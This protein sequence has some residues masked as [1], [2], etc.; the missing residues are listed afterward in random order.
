MDGNGVLSSCVKSHSLRYGAILGAAFWATGMILALRAPLTPGHGE[1]PHPGQP[2]NFQEVK[3]VLETHCFKC[4]G[5]D[6]REGKLDLRTR[7]SIIQGGQ[8][9]SAVVAGDENS[10]LL[11]ETISSGRMPPQGEPRPS[12]A[13]LDLIRRWISGGALARGSEAP[14][15]YAS[16]PGQEDRSF[17][18]FRSP[19]R[20]QVPQV[21]HRSR[22]R[23]PIDAF[24]LAKLEAKGMVLS[25]EADRR[26]LLR[27]AS[28][29]LIGLPPGP[30]EIDDFVAD[31]QPGAYGRLLDRLLS[32]PRYGERWGRHW[33]DTVGYADS[34]G[35]WDS[36]NVRESAYRFRDY[37]IRS[38]NADKPYDQ[39]LLEQVAGDEMV[40]LAA[41]KLEPEMVERLEATGFLRTGADPTYEEYNL[42]E[43]RYTTIDNTIRNFGSS[44]MGL[45]LHCAR[46]HDHKFDP[47]PQRDYY[48][49]EAILKPAYDPDRWIVSEKRGFTEAA[50]PERERARLH[51]E[52]LDKE[53]TALEEQRKEFRL[54]REDQLLQKK[55]ATLPKVLRMDVRA[56]VRT[57]QE[58]RTEVQRYLLAKF[59]DQ[60]EIKEEEFTGAFP[61][62]KEQDAVMEEAIKALQARRIELPHIRGLKDMGPDV[63]D[64]FVRLRGEFDKFGDKVEPGP[65][66]VLSDPMRPFEVPPPGPDARTSGLRTALARWLVHPK[67]P[68]TS[69]VMVNRIWQYHFGEGLV[70]TPDNFGSKGARPTHPELLDWLATEFVRLDWSVKAMHRLIMSSSVYRQVSHKDE[71]NAG[72]DP[73]NRLW[74]RMPL[75]RADGEVIR[76]SMLAASGTLNLQMHGPPVAVEVDEQGEAVTAV[77][78]TARRRSIY[79][80]QRRSRMLTLLKLFDA[81]A[82]EYTCPRRERSTLSTQ[83]LHL[84][85][86]NFTISMSRH[87]ARR[88]LHEMPEAG[89]KERLDYAF[90]VAFGRQPSDRELTWTTSFLDR[91]EEHHMAAPKQP[92]GTEAA[93]P[94]EELPAPDPRLLAWSDL[95]HMLMSANEFVY[96]D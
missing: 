32:S 55:L 71:S 37:V 29:D 80:A 87:F 75:R 84:L 15:S 76:D 6:R 23:T 9:G 59:S 33:L 30:D 20:P 77:E 58:K 66:S 95:C 38:F 90:R 22:L 34:D 4:H 7:E 42:R 53:I 60:V 56:A 16:G 46:C 13:G 92:A 85:N 41:D 19:V 3:L 79:L 11:F 57:E 73:E 27:R 67:H 72:I 17:W 74:W 39:F 51:N 91:Q 63:P 10:S 88:I 64:T 94:P 70:R 8:S 45:T 2:P 52:P 49:L 26:T 40:D 65:L 69:R 89:E 78:A 54:S 81:P 24:I 48:R 5:G 18:S 47:I 44:V 86:S 50:R 61:G 1:E 62:F 83:A 82:M 96:I 35:H 93:P 28:F 21:E 43:Y 36:D 25:A 14:P 12:Q 31:D 68:L